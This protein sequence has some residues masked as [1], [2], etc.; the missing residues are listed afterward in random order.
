M[1]SVSKF[2]DIAVKNLKTVFRDRKNFLFILLVPIFFYSMVGLLFGGV[3]SDEGGYVYKIG[4]VDL[5]NTESN[6]IDHP[7][8]NMTLVR[9]IINEMN[10]FELSVYSTNES[11]KLE[12]ENKEIDAFIVIPDGFELYING[13]GPEPEI[14]LKI[15]FRDSTE[16][17]TKNMLSSML[18]NIITGI[19]NYNPSAISIQFQVDSVTGE[20]VNNI[21]IGAPGY[22]MY[23]MLS[24]LAGAV[25]ILTS[26]RKE[27]L[28]KR[29]ESSELKSSDMLAGHLV[30]NGIFVILQFAIGIVVLSLFGFHPIYSDLGSLLIGTALAVIVSSLFIN[31]LALISAII[32]KTPEAAG[33]GVWIIILPL[34]MLSGAFFPLELVAP[35]LIPYVSWLPT[36]IIVVIFM[37]LFVNQINLLNIQLWINLGIVLLYALI[38]FGIGIKSYQ[39]FARSQ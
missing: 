7:T 6:N 39:K 30:S 14:P 17:I 18:G 28:L 5:D 34:M 19:I 38:L 20:I 23:G 12:L 33:G 26:E 4:W 11:A 8:Y 32:F 24:S 9:D 15:F 29:L 2:W 3:I 36:R 27:G 1:K 10:T 37:D 13:S 31:S 25:I 35:I 16:E 22:V 21:T